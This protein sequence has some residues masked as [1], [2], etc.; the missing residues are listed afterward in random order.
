MKIMLVCRCY[1]TQ[2][3]GGML[4]VCQDRARALA[5]QGHDVLVVTTQAKKGVAVDLHENDRGVKVWHLGDAE[6]CAYSDAFARG[7][8]RAAQQFEPTILHL[9]SV[10]FKREWW[11]GV[12]AKAKVVTMH[13]FG[14]GAW[15]TKWNLA[16]IGE[17]GFDDA[18]L[19]LTKLAA[20]AGEAEIL[21]NTFDRVLAISKHEFDLLQD[22]YGVRRSRLRVVYNPIAEDF[23]DLP[24]VPRPGRPAFLCAAI[25][26]QGERLF[27]LAK[28]AA[29]KAGIPL[30]TVSDVPRTAMP[31]QY[32]A[33]SAVIVPTAYAQGFDLTIAE[34][35]AR[36]RPAIVSSTGSYHRHA[37]E[38]SIIETDLGD[39]DD[40]A[41]EMSRVVDGDDDREWHVEGAQR[42]RPD[43]HA[44]NWL[45]AIGV[46]DE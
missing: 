19:D 44:D 29:K 22:F 11:P 18:T 16:R 14:A 42:H 6:W 25:S 43:I 35:N 27:S 2:R 12:K 15:L 1:P 7:C 20:M 3:P 4:F 5:A 28:A 21:R 37:D 26:G 23:F 30:R 38:R 8:V 9:D 36:G 40:L 39:V 33:V 46:D 45:A 32:D 31:A 13:G 41:Y 34:A 10:D 17:K 24:V